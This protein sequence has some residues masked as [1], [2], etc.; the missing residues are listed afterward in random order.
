M[1]KICR[2]LRIILILF[3]FHN[4]WALATTLEFSPDPKIRVFLSINGNTLSYR[5]VGQHVV[6][7]QIVFETE[8]KIH[9]EIEDYN[10]S[11]KKNI[12]V[13][14]IDDGMGTTTVHRVFLYSI[15]KKN[16]VEYFPVCGDQFINLRVDKKTKTLRSTYFA[17]N[18]PK[19]CSTRL[20]RKVN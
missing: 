19:L 13:W 20:P 1:M 4:S 11:G 17:D 5:I 6:V 16:F 7:D 8:K 15:K 9:L 14:Y 2:T 10:F 3:L 12:S 18:I